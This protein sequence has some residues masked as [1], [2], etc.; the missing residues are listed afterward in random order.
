[1]V[2]AISEGRRICL[3]TFKWTTICVWCL[4]LTRNRTRKSVKSSARPNG[5]PLVFPPSPPPSIL[6]VYTS[7]SQPAQLWY[8]SSCCIIPITTYIIKLFLLPLHHCYFLPDMNQNVGSCTFQ[9]SLATLVNGLF[10][11]HGAHDPQVEN[12][13][14]IRRH[15]CSFIDLRTSRVTAGP[16]PAGSTSCLI[17]VTDDH[18]GFLLTLGERCFWVILLMQWRSSV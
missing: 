8:S 11:S 3:E 1:M 2:R 9:W 5:R 10:D 18:S 13:W 14:S 16:S 6:S 7:G 17:Q 12:Y 15:T 4:Q